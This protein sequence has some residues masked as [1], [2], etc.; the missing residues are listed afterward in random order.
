M[1]AET[2]QKIKQWPTHM[3]RGLKDNMTAWDNGLLVGL[4]LLFMISSLLMIANETNHNF[5]FEKQSARFM[6]GFVVMIIAANIPLHLYQKHALNSYLACVF[7]LLLVLFF[8]HIG[9]GAQ[10]WLHVGIVQFQP[11]EIMKIALPLFLAHTLDRYGSTDNIH[12]LCRCLCIIAIPFILILKQPDLGTALMTL[13]TALTLLFFSGL[14]MRLITFTALTLLP[15]AP[16]FWKYLLH[17]YQKKRI[18][19]FLNPESDPLGSGY[20]IFQAKIAI[21]SGGLLGKGW[22]HG[23]Q[24]KLNFIPEHT[25]DFVFSV[26]AE[27]FGLIGAVLFLLLTLFISM[28]MI[29]IAVKAHSNFAKILCTGIAMN[30]FLATLINVG[31]VCGIFPVVGIPLPLISYGG[32]SMV[33]MM[34][35]FGIVLAIKKSRYLD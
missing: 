34:A 32:T 6:I 20:H 29:R 35:S 16:I 18:L 31:M 26:A 25:T 23:T 5:I 24:Y 1:Q 21:G 22:L 15:L 30:F 8:G 27:E 4:L 7:L 14:S 10:R 11:S 3:I 33:L 28:R 19:V 9:K 17:G 2:V 13:M 12:V